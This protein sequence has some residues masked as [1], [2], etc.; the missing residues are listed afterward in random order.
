[1]SIRSASVVGPSSSPLPSPES[2]PKLPRA[3]AGDKRSQGE[4]AG[5]ALDALTAQLPPSQDEMLVI[6]QAR[7]PDQYFNAEQQQRMAEL[8]EH[9]RTARSQGSCLPSD[10]QHELDTL[11]DL[12]LRASAARAAA[13]ADEAGR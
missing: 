8:M 13:L 5:R 3:V 12:E 10:E 11:V 6:V 7:R 1:M 2:S 4:T 9:W